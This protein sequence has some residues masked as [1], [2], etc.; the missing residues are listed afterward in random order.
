MKL[1]ELC[2]VFLS[3]AQEQRRVVAAIE[4]SHLDDDVVREETIPTSSPS[5]NSTSCTVPSLSPRWPIMTFSR[6]RISM[7]PGDLSAVISSCGFLVS[8]VDHDPLE[9]AD[10]VAV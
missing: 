4:E 9:G 5:S 6:W 2:D 1:R 3:H 8:P 10:V 7:S